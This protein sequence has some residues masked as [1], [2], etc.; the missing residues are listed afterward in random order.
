MDELQS[1]ST[2]TKCFFFSTLRRGEELNWIHWVDDSP[3]ATASSPFL[4][5]SF[6]L[7]AP[8]PKGI[9]NEH[10]FSICRVAKDFLRTTLKDAKWTIKFYQISKQAATNVVEM[11]ASTVPYHLI[12]LPHL[13]SGTLITHHTFPSSLERHLTNK[14][15]NEPPIHYKFSLIYRVGESV[16]NV[17]LPKLFPNQRF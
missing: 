15:I 1:V 4:S 10:H 8:P 11:N 5:A 6:S 9:N 12:P 3:F 16:P 17:F 7:A 2:Q 14:L 13:L